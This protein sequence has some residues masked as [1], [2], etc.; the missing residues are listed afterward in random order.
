VLAINRL[1]ERL[2]DLHVSPT[3]EPVR[4]MLFG[5]RGMTRLNLSFSPTERVNNVSQ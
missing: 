3:A 1:L 2:P 5:I 4:Q